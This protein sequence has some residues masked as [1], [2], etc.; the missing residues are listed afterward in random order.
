[1]PEN[2]FVYPQF[3]HITYRLVSDSVELSRTTLP[4]LSVRS[5]CEI[6]KDTDHVT[7]AANGTEIAVFGISFFT[8]YIRQI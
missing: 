3:N 5:P 6:I 7:T 4:F 8:F 2:S 1:M